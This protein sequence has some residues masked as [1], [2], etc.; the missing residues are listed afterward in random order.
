[1][2]LSAKDFGSDGHVP[3]YVSEHLCRDLK[4]L[5]MQAAAK[6]REGN[7]K[8]AWVKNGQIFA[9]KK[10]A[11]SIVKLTLSSDIENISRD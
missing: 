8:F 11:A 1:M 10:E 2:R 4:C 9:K 7:W 3:F 5:L 6:K